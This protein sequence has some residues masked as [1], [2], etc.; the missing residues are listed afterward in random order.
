LPPAVEDG[1]CLLA[2]PRRRPPVPAPMGDGA[3]PCF[4]LVR[5]IR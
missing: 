3:A 2:R 5:T 4:R 1:F